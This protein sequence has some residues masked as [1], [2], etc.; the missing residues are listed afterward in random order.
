MPDTPLRVL[1][2]DDCPDNRECLALLLLASGHE[3][4]FACDGPSALEAGRSFGPHVVLLD[5]A[6][7]GMDGW[8]VG[9][10]L[11][12]RQ[13]DRA[14]LLVA[15]TGH[16]RQ[17]DKVR[18]RQAGFDAH[19][20]KPADVEELLGLLTDAAAALFPVGIS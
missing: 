8:E 19:L 20:V 1:V 13:G 4:V 3:V 16:G 2:V 11:R 9:R 15:L 17:E 12:E 14:V 7:P 18:S 6:L 10:R 5:I